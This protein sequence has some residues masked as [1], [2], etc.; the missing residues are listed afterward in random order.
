ML[1]MAENPAETKKMLADQLR[2]YINI[3]RVAA[4]GMVDDVID[5][6]DTRPLLARAL[7]LTQHKHVERPRRRR[8]VSPV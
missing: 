1:A 3:Y 6:R 4:L 8:E 5:P 2:P 7:K